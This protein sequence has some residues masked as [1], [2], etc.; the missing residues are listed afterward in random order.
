MVAENA[1]GL[2][3]LDSA[4]EDVKRILR[5]HALQMTTSEAM[6]EKS[7]EAD[8]AAFRKM[9][10]EEAAVRRRERE[11]KDAKRE[12]AHEAERVAEEKKLKEAMS[13]MVSFFGELLDYELGDVMVAKF[14]KLGYKFYDDPSYKCT[15]DGKIGCRSVTFSWMLFGKG[16]MLAVDAS[17]NKLSLIDV[18]KHM[19]KLDKLRRYANNPRAQSYLRKNRLYGAVAG[20]YVRADVRKYVLE[21]GL[22]LIEPFDDSIHITKPP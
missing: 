18:D 6:Y 4:L 22:F 5:G 9:L 3:R 14:R 19:E 17:Y 7:R 8:V 10:A 2:E 13:D 11:E 20:A 16:Q 12:A 15:T 1:R 21:H